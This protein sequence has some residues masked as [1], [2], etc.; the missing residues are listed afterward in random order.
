MSGQIIINI[1]LFRE[2]NLN[3]FFLSIDKKLYKNNLNDDS[4]FEDRS[5]GNNEL[6]TK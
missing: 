3:Y 5:S 4:Y 1:T 6:I 2:K